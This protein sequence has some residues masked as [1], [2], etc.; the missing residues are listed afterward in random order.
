MLE[1]LQALQRRGYIASDTAGGIAVVD[2]GPSIKTAELL[3]DHVESMVENA[4]GEEMAP[5]IPPEEYE[6]SLPAIEMTK[7]IGRCQLPEIEP[8]EAYCEL[9]ENI[10]RDL[11]SARR[12]RSLLVTA[13][14]ETALANFSILDLAVALSSHG[15][16]LVI[17]LGNTLPIAREEGRQGFRELLAGRAT[18]REV[19]APTNMPRIAI[20][21]SG[22]ALET[23]PGTEACSKHLFS[24]LAPMHQFVLVGGSQS[25]EEATCWIASAC[26][27]TYFLVELGIDD[28]GHVEKAVRRLRSAGAKVRGAIAVAS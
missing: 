16:V 4:G 3:L 28:A 19:V 8:G 17:D 7:A 21:A 23:A 14:R 25:D 18:W 26:R 11:K 12:P 20:V 2:H 15:K 10:A 5:S 22:G 27:A 24:A 13:L 1:A 9:A 6:Q